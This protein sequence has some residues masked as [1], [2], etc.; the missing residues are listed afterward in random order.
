M[1]TQKE[2]FEEIENAI[3]RSKKKGIGVEKFE[4][5]NRVFYIEQ[6]SINA[7][8]IQLLEYDAAGNQLRCRLFT[9]VKKEGVM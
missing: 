8:A 9:Y 4:F 2:F 1:T 5:N 7:Y 3:A 6:R